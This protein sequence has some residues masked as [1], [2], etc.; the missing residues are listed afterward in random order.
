MINLHPHMLRRAYHMIVPPAASAIRTHLTIS[1]LEQ[2]PTLQS[3]PVQATASAPVNPSAPPST[4][5]QIKPMKQ[6]HPAASPDTT[7][8]TAS[9]VPKLPPPLQPRSISPTTVLEYP[10]T[11]TITD[12]TPQQHSNRATSNNRSKTPQRIHRWFQSLLLP[13]TLNKIYPQRQLWD[14][15]LNHAHLSD[16]HKS[17]TYF[18]PTEYYHSCPVIT[19][20]RV[21]R[22]STKLTSI[23]ADIT[24]IFAKGFECQRPSHGQQKGGSPREP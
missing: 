8:S 23:N 13:T 9:K 18:F 6:V 21:V 16:T 14:Q 2:P 11:P 1:P 7:T 15:F 24:A 10:L 17:N 4:S 3:A 12:N 5:Q 22:P 19:W 20:K